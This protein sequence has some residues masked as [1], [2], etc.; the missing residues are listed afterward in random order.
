[1]QRHTLHASETC[2]SKVQGLQYP[3]NVHCSTG[4]YEPSSQALLWGTCPAS[5]T[6]HD[7]RSCV[8]GQRTQAQMQ[9]LEALQVKQQAVLRR[10]TQEAEAARKRL[11]VVV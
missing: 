8:Q 3:K 10:K 9:R 1:M 5:R 2:V 11:K 4:P 7:G 6:A